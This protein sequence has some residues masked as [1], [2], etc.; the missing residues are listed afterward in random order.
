MKISKIGKNIL[1]GEIKLSKNRKTTWEKIKSAILSEMSLEDIVEM[2]AFGSCIKP[3][4][5]RVIE[6]KEH[7]FFGLFR[8]KEPNIVENIYPN[9]VDILVL[10]KEKPTSGWRK[11]VLHVT[12][13]SKEYWDKALKEGDLETVE[14][15]KNSV[16]L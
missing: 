7:S 8:S 15:N 2:R 13:V 14:I 10:T 16:M 11:D 1:S 3:L 5:T 9:D 12:I 6:G 4:K